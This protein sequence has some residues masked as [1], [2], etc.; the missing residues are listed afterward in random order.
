[1]FETNGD[2]NNDDEVF[3]VAHLALEG[4]LGGW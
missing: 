1:M 3:E 2:W 4:E